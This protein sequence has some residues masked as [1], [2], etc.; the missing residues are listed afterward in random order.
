MPYKKPILL[1]FSLVTR[2][3]LIYLYYGHFKMN[4][5]NTKLYKPEYSNVK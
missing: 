4:S 1:V 3:S 5:L 2:Q